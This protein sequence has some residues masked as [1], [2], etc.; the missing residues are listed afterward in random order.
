[1]SR[2]VYQII[3]TGHRTAERWRR[4][5]VEPGTAMHLGG[6]AWAEVVRDRDAV[7][8][9]ILLRIA[10]AAP[11]MPRLPLPLIPTEAA[12]APWLFLVPRAVAYDDLGRPSRVLLEFQEQPERG[13]AA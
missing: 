13:A 1:M 3:T 12:Y 7:D 5:W 8:D 6:G 10:F 4:C 11:G 2:G 9:E